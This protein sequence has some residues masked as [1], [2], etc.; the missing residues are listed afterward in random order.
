MKKILLLIC[1]LTALVSCNKDD[2]IAP[3]I[4]G[5]MVIPLPP[6]FV[7]F[8]PV[9]AELYTTANITLK[10]TITGKSFSYTYGKGLLRISELGETIFESEEKAEVSEI[11]GGLKEAG[12]D[13]EYYPADSAYV[14]EYVNIDGITRTIYVPAMAYRI[15][16]KSPQPNVEFLVNGKIIPA[17]SLADSMKK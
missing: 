1:A 8:L 7:S 13:Y 9:W 12:F 14:Y 17:Q 6:D 4:S 5:G 11:E 3:P 16:W 2:E 15:K 10:N